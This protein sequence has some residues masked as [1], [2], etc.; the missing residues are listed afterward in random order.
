M[1]SALSGRASDAPTRS[2]APTSPCTAPS[3]GVSF[4]DLPDEVVDTIGALATPAA[5]ATL[6][7]TCR[8][9]A[10]RYRGRRAEHRR[11]AEALL[12]EKLAQSALT[13]SRL[14][15]CSGTPASPDLH[16]Q[17]QLPV[18]KWELR[19]LTDADVFLL[20][21]ALKAKGSPAVRISLYGNC[22]GD[23]GCRALA[24]CVDEG[25][26]PHLSELTLANNTF[27]PGGQGCKALAQACRRRG[28][29]VFM[30]VS[31]EM[32]WLSLPSIVW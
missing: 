30:R 28:V 26:L 9:Y 23:A 1:G 25:A 12:A 22:I 6:S 27:E 20:A 2:D 14:R 3:D 19:E 4:A 24:R 8:A 10:E 31:N 13:Q 11:E 32:E 5:L 17:L 21:A 29:R 7:C 15:H 16:R 18:L